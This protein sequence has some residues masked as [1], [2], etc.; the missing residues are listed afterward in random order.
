MWW[1]CHF[2]HSD[3][4]QGQQLMGPFVLHNQLTIPVPRPM[5]RFWKYLQGEVH[6]AFFLGHANCARQL[7]NVRSHS[8]SW[9]EHRLPWPFLVPTKY[10]QTILGSLLSVCHSPTA[11]RG[12]SVAFPLVGDKVGQ[13]VLLGHA[14]GRSVAP[15]VHLAAPETQLNTENWAVQLLSS[16]N[17]SPS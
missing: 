15:V 12:P 11:I 14:G 2:G 6:I 4:V 3:G 9:W 13:V 17:K 8:H 1:W 16:L 7:T 5:N 10:E